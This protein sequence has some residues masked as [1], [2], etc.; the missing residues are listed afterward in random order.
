MKAKNV[1]QFEL[2]KKLQEAVKCGSYM[3]TVTHFDKKEKQMHHYTATSNFP[4]EDILLALE[5]H[6]VNMQDEIAANE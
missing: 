4:R 6:V 5:S 2:Y 3:V 1:G